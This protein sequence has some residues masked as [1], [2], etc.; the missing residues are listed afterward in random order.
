MPK[1]RLQ[2]YYIFQIK[3]I[4]IRFFSEKTAKKHICRL[5]YRRFIYPVNPYIQN[6]NLNSAKIL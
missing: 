3:N 1:I 6:N 5:I 4:L 2:I